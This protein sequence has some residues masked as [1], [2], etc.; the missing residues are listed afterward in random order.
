[1]DY[2]TK[3]MNGTSGPI[4]AS[5]R[6]RCVHCFQAGLVREVQ[7]SGPKLTGSRISGIATGTYN[8]AGIIDQ[9]SRS[10][11]H[12][13]NTYYNA[14]VPPRLNLQLLTEALVEKILLEQTPD[15]F[16]Q[17]TRMRISTK[18]GEK[19]Q[20][21]ILAAGTIRNGTMRCVPTSQD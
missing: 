5:P 18:A 14:E 21:V 17:A 15:D 3:E 11:S 20:E 8:S 7:D 2:L 9:N 12:A 16:N 1:M 13:G 6:E 19:H 4:Q 10:R